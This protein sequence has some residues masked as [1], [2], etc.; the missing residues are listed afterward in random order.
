LLTEYIK[1]LM[2]LKSL[3]FLP[4]GPYSALTR[5]NLSQSGLNI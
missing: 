2:A 5:P 1:P 3:V 4:F